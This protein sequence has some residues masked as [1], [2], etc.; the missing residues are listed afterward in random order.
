METATFVIVVVLLVLELL[1]LFGVRARFARGAWR[2]LATEIADELEARH[3]AGVEVRFD[4]RREVDE[5]L[6]RL[7]LLGSNVE[8]V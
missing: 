8:D 4:V 1:G 7:G 5:E 3:L 6:R 2:R